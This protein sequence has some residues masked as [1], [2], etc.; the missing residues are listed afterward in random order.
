MKNGSETHPSLESRLDLVERRMRR[1]RRNLNRQVQRALVPLEIQEDVGISQ[2]E[3]DVLIVSDNPHI[4]QKVQQLLRSEKYR[5]DIAEGG[6]EAVGYLKLGTYRMVIL[7]RSRRRRSQ[8]FRHIRRYL[9]HIKVISIVNDEK[10][11]RASMQLGGYSYLLGENFDP[12]Q[13]RTCLI[14][15]LRMEHRVCH[16]LANGEPCNRS[17][18]NNYLSEDDYSELDYADPDFLPPDPL[19]MQGPSPIEEL[20]ELQNP[21][22]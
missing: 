19:Q 11:A 7:D 22:E 9:R 15:S 8:V 3:G 13:L 5:C 4:Q 20:E 1:A 12:E 21:D 17:C 14:S 16:L 18:I 10:R 2:I 6:D